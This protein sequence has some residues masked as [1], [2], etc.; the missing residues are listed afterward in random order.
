MGCGWGSAGA[1]ANQNPAKVINLSLTSR[2][3]CPNSVLQAIIQARSRGSIVVASAG[4]DEI[5]VS[6]AWPANCAGALVV[7][8]VNRSGIKYFKS[9]TGSLV[10]ISAPGVDIQVITNSGTTVP[11]ADIS[12]SV[13]GTSPAAAHVSAAAALMMSRNS[14]LTPDDV[15]I[16]LKGTARPFPTACEGCGSGMLNI[17]AALEVLLPTAPQGTLTINGG[18]HNS[19]TSYLVIKNTGAGW[20]TGITASCQDPGS[21]VTVA[22]PSALGP[23]QSMY[24]HATV[25]SWSYRCNYL[26]R[27]NN[28]TNAPL[29]WSYF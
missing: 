12:I 16:I 29:L 25:G 19:S 28:S 6:G 5:D 22:P 7:A 21:Q 17:R 9:N 3:N 20:I 23:G 15:A 2:T 26:I 10:G 27:A 18:S 8:A 4:N 14:V 24:V 1:P 11:L 13:D